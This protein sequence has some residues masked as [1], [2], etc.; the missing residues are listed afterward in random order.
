MAGIDNL[1]TIGIAFG[2][3]ALAAPV[4]E[5]LKKYLSKKLSKDLEVQFKTPSGQTVK[6]SL[7]ATGDKAQDAIAVARAVQETQAI[8]ATQSRVTPVSSQPDSA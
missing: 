4:G 1:V 2:F 7:E 3:S 5:F 6:I 8:G